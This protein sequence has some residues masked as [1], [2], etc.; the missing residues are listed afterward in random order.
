MT[1]V[2]SE[3]V[4]EAKSTTGEEPSSSFTESSLVIFSNVS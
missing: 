1:I 3:S 4:L 2:S